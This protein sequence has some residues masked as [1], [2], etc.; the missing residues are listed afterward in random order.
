MGEITGCR[1]L[2]KGQFF[3]IGKK[4]PAGHRRLHILIEGN[5]KHE[6]QGA[7]KEIKRNIDELIMNNARYGYG[8]GYTEFSGSFGKF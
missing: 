7:Q 5:S 2:V 6:V 4:P 3:E 8:G 1:V